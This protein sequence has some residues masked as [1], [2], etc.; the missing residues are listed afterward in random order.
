MAHLIKTT[1]LAFLGL[2]LFSSAALAD[3]APASTGADG[4]SYYG[5]LGIQAN[6]SKQ[7]HSKLNDIFFCNKLEI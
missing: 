4:P 1:A 6:K 5:S 3:E 7:S 2:G